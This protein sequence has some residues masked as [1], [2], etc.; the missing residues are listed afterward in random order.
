MD[1]QALRDHYGEI[2]LDLVRVTRYPSVAILQRV[3]T[4]IRDMD[5]ATE[6]VELLMEKVQDD[7]F[8]SPEMLDRIST[9][10]KR[11]E[12][13]GQGPRSTSNGG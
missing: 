2:L 3:E 11:L 10:M 12:T 13:A 1:I 8:P 9:L 6:Y 5:A 7:R 4:G